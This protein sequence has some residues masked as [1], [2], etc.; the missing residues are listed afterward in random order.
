MQLVIK[1]AERL[2]RSSTEILDP[3]LLTA[4]AHGLERPR[5]WRS[6]SRSGQDDPQECIEAG[7]SIIS[8]GTAER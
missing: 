6:C 1:K 7:G 3:A 2:T 8:G 4:M 5:R